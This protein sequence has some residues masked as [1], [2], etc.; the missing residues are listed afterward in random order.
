MNRNVLKMSPAHSGETVVLHTAVQDEFIQK[1]NQNGINDAIEWL[2]TCDRTRDLTHPNPVKF[3][4]EAEAEHSVFAISEYDDFRDAKIYKTQE[5]VCVVENLKI[6]QRYYWRVNRGEVFH[7]ETANEF[8][9]FLCIDGISNVRDLGG[10]SIRQGLVYRGSALYEDS[11]NGKY[12]ITDEGRHTFCEELGIKTDLDLRLEALG[13]YVESPAG[14]EV[15]L[16]QIPYR[17]YKEIFEPEY[18]NAICRI[19]EVFAD[20]SNYPIYFHCAGGADRTGMIAMYLRA[21]AGEAD[22]DVHLDYELTSLSAGLNRR[23]TAEYYVEMLDMLAEYAPG[24]TFSKQLILFL[25]SCGV[26]EECRQ[27]IRNILIGER[28]I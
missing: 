24:E 27:K 2:E 10:L 20:E 15:R 11:A 14:S 18:R 25:D 26:T 17:P 28:T 6:G 5:E 19:M 7:F 4:W 1:I 13:K 22:K 21:I 12:A 9:R 23:R 16:I 8:P 3:E